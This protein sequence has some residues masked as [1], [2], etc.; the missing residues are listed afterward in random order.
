MGGH[1]SAPGV[2]GRGRGDAVAPALR[3]TTHFASPRGSGSTGSC[4]NLRADCPARKST[5][6][7]YWKCSPGALL[8][9]KCDLGDVRLRLGFPTATPHFPREG[10]P[11]REIRVIFKREITCRQGDRLPLPRIWR[12]QDSNLRFRGAPCPAITG[13]SKLYKICTREL[14]VN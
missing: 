1:R 9:R 10:R 8:E 14:P 13:Q 2:W 12:R 7:A 4:V 5:Q 3:E 11:I 6:N